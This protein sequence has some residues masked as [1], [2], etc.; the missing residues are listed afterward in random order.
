MT[1]NQA[2]TEAIFYTISAGYSQS[3]RGIRTL[4]LANQH[5]KIEMRYPIVSILNRKLGYK[6]M[7]AEAWWV[8]SGGAMLEDIAPYAP[9]LRRF[10]NDNWT[11]D[12][13]YGPKVLNQMR[14]VVDTLSNDQNSRQAVMSL[15]SPNPRFS[16]DIPCTLSLQFLLRNN[17][18]LH[19][20]ASMRSSDLITGWPYDVFTFT[21]ISAVV[22][23]Q[24]A[25]RLKVRI[26]LGYLYINAGSQHIYE[27]DLP[28]ARECIGLG[29]TILGY[30]P[31]EHTKYDNPDHLINVLGYLK[32]IPKDQSGPDLFG[33]K[34]PPHE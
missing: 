9:E 15:W 3:P 2:W 4:E 22:A 21:M 10:T 25:K 26:D 20:I 32:D 11:L 12:G 29:A 31:F 8:L 34:I 14:Y 28:I 16:F 30:T 19:T 33:H 1:A 13:A 17:G 7:P 23:M 18:I 5:T 24:I 27:K 6:F